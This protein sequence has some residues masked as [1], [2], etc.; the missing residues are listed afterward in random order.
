MNQGK[1]KD[2]FLALN[3]E[4][5]MDTDS[6][7]YLVN[8]LGLQDE[9]LSCLLTVP[10]NERLRLLGFMLG[11]SLLSAELLAD[12]FI[13][14]IDFLV[15]GEY[16]RMI[17]S[18]SSNVSDELSALWTDRLKEQ[19]SRR[20]LFRV[21]LKRILSRLFVRLIRTNMRVQGRAQ[22]DR[23][24]DSLPM[25]GGPEAALGIVQRLLE[26]TV[27]L[28]IELGENG[29]EVDQDLQK[30]FERWDTL[31]PRF[32]DILR[33][34]H[35]FPGTLKR[36]CTEESPS[37]S[38]AERVQMR[39]QED[40][41]SVKKAESNRDRALDYTLSTKPLNDH[42][43]AFVQICSTVRRYQDLPESPSCF[44][45]RLTSDMSTFSLDQN[46]VFKGYIMWVESRIQNQ[47]AGWRS[48]VKLKL[49]FFA[50]FEES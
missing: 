38:L 13:W 40:L 15:S 19:E 43:K 39:Q 9:L 20:R 12:L 5:P 37:I 35:C 28:V 23:D 18:G 41:A 30:D 26:D 21:S 2:E 7:L 32:S 11:S 10:H 29:H 1:C 3:A 45:T 17:E 8:G 47:S 50:V 49:Q 24:S 16:N 34:R 6:Y 33:S 31:I 27:R 14:T 36:Q 42:Q 44:I 46:E 22:V 4:W 48:C 25:T